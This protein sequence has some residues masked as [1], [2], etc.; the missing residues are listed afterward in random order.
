M[1]S[2]RNHKSTPFVPKHLIPNLSEEVKR[3]S[4]GGV[5]GIDLPELVNFNMPYPDEPNGETVPAIQF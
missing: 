3:A 5:Y 2:P 1:T 4:V